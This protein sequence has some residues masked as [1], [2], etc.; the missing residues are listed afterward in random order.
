[1]RALVVTGGHP[2]VAAP[3]FAVFD[4]IPDLE[5]RHVKQPA[6]AETLDEAAK[7]CDVVVFYDMPGITFT[8]A[9]PPIEVLTPTPKAIAAFESLLAASTP[10]VFLHH[11]IAGWPSWD[12]YAEVI[13]G[14]FHYRSATLRGVDYPASGYRFDAEHA[15][16][17][18]DPS[19]PICDGL[20][21][22]FTIADELYQ[23]PAFESEVTPL[24]RSQARFESD[25]FFSADLAIRG[26][27][28]SRSGWSHPSGTNLVAWV[29]EEGD[30]PV[31]YI[32]FGDGPT[33]YA[34]PNYRRVI[35]NAIRWGASAR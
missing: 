23:F 29:R 17:V 9:D 32:Q 22:T 18:L 25:E 34:D 15:V 11:A 24:M 14:R 10:L 31:A 21:A 3:F 1:V 19:H 2:F 27:R 6:A 33:T 30:T 26:E 5:W 4:A 8:R 20:D 16:E 28:E 12:R 13:G 7:D 35:A